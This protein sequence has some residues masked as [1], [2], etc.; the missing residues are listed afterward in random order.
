LLAVP[1]SFESRGHWAGDNLMRLAG[2]AKVGT[3]F[4]AH[5]IYFTGRYWVHS[6]DMDFEPGVETF[7]VGEDITAW[8]DDHPMDLQIA[9]DNPLIIKDSYGD[10]YV[11]ERS[12]FEAFCEVDLLST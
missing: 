11:V 8:E 10:I 3:E 7:P 9:L 12:I 4:N 2:Y 1:D 5:H 6:V